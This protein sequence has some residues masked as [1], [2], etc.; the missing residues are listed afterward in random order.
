MTFTRIRTHD[1]SSVG[2]SIC[3][4]LLLNMKKTKIMTIA[5]GLNEFTLGTEKVEVAD[6]FTFLGS[7][8]DRKGGCSDDI[9]KM[10]S[11][12]KSSDDQTHKNYEGL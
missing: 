7:T 4:D 3:E 1:L 8:I 11:L 10:P 2:C 12:R 5:P 6:S 9:K